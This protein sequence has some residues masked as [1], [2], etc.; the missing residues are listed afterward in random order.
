MKS[1][2]ISS[3]LA[4]HAGVGQHFVDVEKLCSKAIRKSNGDLCT[5]I[6]ILEDNPNCNAGYGSN[7][8]ESGC[9]EC[10][11]A[12]CSSE[13]QLFAAVGALRRIR[14]PIYLARELAEHQLIASCH[15]L[16]PPS[17]LVSDGAETFAVDRGFELCSPV[18]LISKSAHDQWEKAKEIIDI[19]SSQ[20]IEK[21]KLDTVG[22]IS[23]DAD[24]KTQ[25]GCSSG[26]LLLKK[27]G[28]L[29][30]CVQ[31]GGAVWAEQIG[32]KS[33]AVTLS[34]CGEYIA[35]TQLAK[36]LGRTALQ[37]SDG[38]KLLVNC[39]E[40]AFK[41]EF[42]LS[43][44]LAR[45]PKSRV[46]AGGLLIFSDKD[47]AAAELVVFHNTDELAFAFNEDGTIKKAISRATNSAVTVES[48]P[49]H[50]FLSK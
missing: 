9:V 23:L 1:E 34:G 29:G 40:D 19:G 12:F 20:C 42:V 41:S 2:T 14:N 4:V 16:I 17:V 32:S 48:Y 30:H 46:L 22:A 10:E 26:G 21:Y 8:S 13:E 35:R 36:C 3:I 45:Y 28:R 37:S 7:L 11:A 6:K 39:I 50:A 49:L 15:D 47:Y 25:A 18:E 31:Y 38:D 33:V 24:G 43:P 44:L 27:S 5:A